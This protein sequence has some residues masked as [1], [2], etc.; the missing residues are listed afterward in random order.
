MRVWSRIALVVITLFSTSTLFAD[1]LSAQCPLSL[2]DS[3]PAA[4]SFDLS[5]HGVF[6]SGNTVYA[7]RGQVL[8]TYTPNDVGNLSISRED[9]QIGRAHV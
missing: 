4:T 9:F 5:P 1:H 3:T 2:A 6:R 8:T 7:L